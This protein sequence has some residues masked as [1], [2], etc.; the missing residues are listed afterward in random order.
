M[1]YEVQCLKT[2][3]VHEWPGPFRSGFPLPKFKHSSNPNTKLKKK[4]GQTARLFGHRIGAGFPN[5]SN[6]TIGE[7]GIDYYISHPALPASKNV[8]V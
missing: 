2:V 1:G 7:E 4:K 8:F 5:A 6:T 3:S